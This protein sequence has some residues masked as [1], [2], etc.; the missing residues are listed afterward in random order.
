[1]AN[2]NSPV[3]S[4]NKTIQSQ[5]V[6]FTS[7]QIAKTVNKINRFA[8]YVSASLQESEMNYVV[9]VL[10]DLQSKYMITFD[11]PDILQYRHDDEY[12]ID[13]EDID[14]EAA[15]DLKAA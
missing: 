14:A 2:I 13:F 8:I 15:E 10:E 7:A 9:Q 6:T 12:T 5:P 4:M 11:V 3:L 1:M